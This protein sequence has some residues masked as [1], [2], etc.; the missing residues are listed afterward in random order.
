MVLSTQFDRIHHQHLAH[1]GNLLGSV[2]PGGEKHHVGQWW[3]KNMLNLYKVEE[4]RKEIDAAM[5]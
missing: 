5:R 1:A 4:L 2:P 3:R